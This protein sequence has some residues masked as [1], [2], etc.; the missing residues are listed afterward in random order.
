MRTPR[1]VIPP[2]CEETEQIRGGHHHVKI[3]AAALAQDTRGELLRRTAP[4]FARE[5]PRLQAGKYVDGLL[6]DLPRC[7]TCPARTVGRWPSAPA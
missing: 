3:D 2:D 5:Q 4:L 6:S 1:P 7:P